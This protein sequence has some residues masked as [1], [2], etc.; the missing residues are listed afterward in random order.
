ML[1]ILIGKMNDKKFAFTGCTETYEEPRDFE[2][3]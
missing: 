1:L 3:T 2:D